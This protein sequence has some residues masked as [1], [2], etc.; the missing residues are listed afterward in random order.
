MPPMLKTARWELEGNMTLEELNDHF[1]ALKAK[2]AAMDDK[3]LL[4]HHR[5]AERKIAKAQRKGVKPRYIWLHREAVYGGEIK[6]RQ[7]LP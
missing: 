7:G 2:A 3:D 1:A 6:K 4:S 5:Q